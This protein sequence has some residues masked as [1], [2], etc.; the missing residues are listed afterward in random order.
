MIHIIQHE[1][2]CGIRYRHSGGTELVA[3]CVVYRYGAVGMVHVLPGHRRRHLAR[4]MLRL[5]L[6]RYV[7]KP[8]F[9]RDNQVPYAYILPGNTAS[10]QLFGHREIGFQYLQ[11]VVWS[12]VTVT[13]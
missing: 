5:L 10:Q 6:H 11:P 2:T 3:W 9:S 4:H 1:L 13:L 12:T 7:S 8:S